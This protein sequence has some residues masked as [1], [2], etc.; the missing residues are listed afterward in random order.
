MES[1]RSPRT[2]QREFFTGFAL[3][4]GRTYINAIHL[5]EEGEEGLALAVEAGRLPLSPKYSKLSGPS[6]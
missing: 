6:P 5:L 3:G 4:F 1:R 2:N